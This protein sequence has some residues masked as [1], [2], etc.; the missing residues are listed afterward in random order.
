MAD[1][2]CFYWAPPRPFSGTVPLSGT[3]QK[4]ILK[5]DSRA[6]ALYWV[7]ST[8]A[9]HKLL[10]LDQAARI[11]P[12]HPRMSFLALAPSASAPVSSTLRGGVSLLQGG[13]RYRFCRKVLWHSWQS[14]AQPSQHSPYVSAQ[15]GGLLGTQSKEQDSIPWVI[16]RRWDLRN[17][18]LC[19]SPS[20]TCTPCL[21][22]IPA[23]HACTL[24]P[25]P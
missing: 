10:G 25:S 1:A 21:Q 8:I 19:C 22:A 5:S 11:Q 18:K 4:H 7:F 13:P 20:H 9:K 2:P 24:H 3:C 16:P 12:C 17:T 6:L 14:P 15:V 23:S